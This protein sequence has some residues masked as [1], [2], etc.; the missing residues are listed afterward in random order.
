M[1]EEQHLVALFE[2]TYYSANSPATSSRIDYW[3]LASGRHD[4]VQQC[5]VLHNLGAQLQAMRG[6]PPRDHL[7]LCL[8]ARYERDPY[9]PPHVPPRRMDPS[10][11]MQAVRSGKGKSQFLQAVATE[12][13]GREAEFAGY[14]ATGSADTFFEIMED[15]LTTLG[16]RRFARKPLAP[17]PELSR[18]RRELLR[19]RL[20]L[21]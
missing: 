16:H 9:L 2:N 18:Q 1:I 15:V 19:Q 3:F 6:P 5:K 13:E 14:A 21:K 12:F 7:P 4:R 8:V 11:L 10:A 20:A 17:D